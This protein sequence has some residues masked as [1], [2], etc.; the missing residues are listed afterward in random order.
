MTHYWKDNL[1]IWSHC[2]CFRAKSKWWNLKVRLKLSCF[3]PSTS[4][5][6]LCHLSALCM[7]AKVK[8]TRLFYLGYL[9][10][11]G[12]REIN[13]REFQKD[14][15][16][17]VRLH[18]DKNSA[19]VHE[20]RW[21]YEHE[22]FSLEIKWP[23]LTQNAAFSSKCKRTFKRMLGDSNYFCFAYQL[24]CHGG[25]SKTSKRNRPIYWT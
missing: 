18:N 2:L 14:N 20:A 13:P 24:W 5:R 10:D 16:F 9:D 7:L 12:F 4:S 23:I 19:F 1:A 8:L 15:W 3:H 25:Q 11:F 21:F 6:Q 17:M 22:I